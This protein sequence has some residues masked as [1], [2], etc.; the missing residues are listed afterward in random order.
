MHDVIITKIDSPMEEQEEAE[1]VEN[2]GT[3][4]ILLLRAALGVDRPF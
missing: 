1:T 4:T 3:R 2:G